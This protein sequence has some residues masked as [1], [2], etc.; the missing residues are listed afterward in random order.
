[1]KKA[2]AC[3]LLALALVA[4]LEPHVRRQIADAVSARLASREEPAKADA[5]P[6]FSRQLGGAPRTDMLNV[7]L[8]FRFADTAVLGAQ[9]A[10]LDIRRE[11][12][13]ATSIVQRLLEGPDMHHEHLNGVFPQGTELISVRGDGATAFVTLSSAFL[14]KPDGAPADWED[15]TVWQEEAALRRRLAVQSLALALTE[16][17]RYQR[18]QLYVAD[19]DDEIPQRIAMAW[20]DTGVTDPSLVLAACPRDEQALLTPGRAVEMVMDAWQRQSWQEMYPLMADTQ[21]DP[22]P[23]LSVFENEMALSGISLL[24]YSV[25]PGTVSLDGRTATVVLDAQ[26]RSRE[27]GD[28]QIIRESVP[29]VRMQD[30][31]AMEEATLMSLMIR[32]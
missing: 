21:D 15:L 6:A 22:L 24:E 16:D 1:M 30:N 12:T 32:D 4:A 3:L 28:A 27:G 26:I 31:W 29:L 8:Y 7:T 5:A 2:I 13:I 9:S 17:G 25:T 18:M 14:G 11:E 10:Q 19:S 23:T 20:M